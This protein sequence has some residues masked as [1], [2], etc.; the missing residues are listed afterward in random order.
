MYKYL[1]NQ[2][3]KKRKKE[4]YETDFLPQTPERQ[5]ISLMGRASRRQ[6]A[7][8]SSPRARTGV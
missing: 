7:C 5:S 8:L 6:K 4:R 1:F 3:K 2:K